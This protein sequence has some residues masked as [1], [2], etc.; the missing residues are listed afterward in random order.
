MT[1]V[2]A[3]TGAGVAPRASADPR[4]RPRPQHST[5]AIEARVAQMGI[6]GAIVGLSVPGEIDYLHGRWASRDTRL[7][8]RP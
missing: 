8:R 5:G 4:R 6:P 7:G 1:A 2:L 3:F